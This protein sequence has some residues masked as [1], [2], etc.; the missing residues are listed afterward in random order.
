MNTPLNDMD[1]YDPTHDE[2]NTKEPSPNKK[3]SKKTGLKN[4]LSKVKKEQTI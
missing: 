3:S 4:I 2:L 1:L